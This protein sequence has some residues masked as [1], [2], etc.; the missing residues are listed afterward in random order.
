MVNKQDHPACLLL[1]TRSVRNKST[2]LC[3]YVSETNVDLK[4]MNKTWLKASDST[5]VNDLVPPGYDG[6][7]KVVEKLAY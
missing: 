4:Y 7:T 5:I 3:D 6:Q 2:L 1:N